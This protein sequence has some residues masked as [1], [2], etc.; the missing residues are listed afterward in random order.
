MNKKQKYEGYLNESFNRI[1]AKHEIRRELKYPSYNKDLSHNS[2]DV[3]LENKW[4]HASTYG[5]LQ[6]VKGNDLDAYKKGIKNIYVKKKGLAKLDNY[7]EKK[8]FGKIEY[9]EEI[10]YKMKNK[11][12]HFITK[13]LIKY[14]LIFVIFA[15][16]PFLGLIFPTVI[17][18]LYG[19]KDYVFYE[20]GK[21]VG[22][23]FGGDG[24]NKDF[25]VAY[26][27]KT[28]YEVL[29]NLNIVLSY[30]ALAIVILTIIYTVI[31]VIQYDRLKGVK[32]KMSVK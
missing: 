12:N 19:N 6:K 2:M 23:K 8:I 22:D 29:K 9:L 14:F 16:I 32:G 17:Y 24:D 13:K 21:T 10:S 20:D 18:E 3:N 31:K 15:L 11:K 27:R 4:K 28:T 26:F 25:L 1:L 5:L 7:F 30:I